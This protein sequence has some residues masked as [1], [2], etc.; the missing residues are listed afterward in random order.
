MGNR[1]KLRRQFVNGE[2]KYEDLSEAD[3]KYIDRYARRIERDMMDGADAIPTLK[4]VPCQLWPGKKVL[5]PA[6]ALIVE[7]EDG[8]LYLGEVSEKNLIVS[9][10]YKSRERGRKM[11]ESRRRREE[12]EKAVLQMKP[13]TLGED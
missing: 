3:R 10:N 4:E 1:K 12:E 8:L 6:D 7:D 13:T 5:V 2:V 9:E 11:A